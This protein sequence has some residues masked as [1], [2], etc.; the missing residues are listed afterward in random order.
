MDTDKLITEITNSVKQTLKTK[1]TNL[2]EDAYDTGNDARRDEEAV[3]FNLIVNNLWDIDISN[4]DDK[5][6][7]VQIDMAKQQSEYIAD[8][9]LDHALPN[10]QNLDDF[11]YEINS[12]KTEELTDEHVNELLEKY[13]IA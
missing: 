3:M 9:A 2:E 5:A 7:L 1:L 10:D 11:A 4:G 12:I 8:I 13:D 6:R